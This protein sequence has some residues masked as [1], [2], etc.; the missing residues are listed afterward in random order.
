MPCVE[1]IWGQSSP[2]RLAQCSVLD[3]NPRR[4]LAGD[5]G[6]GM[7]SRGLTEVG[8]RTLVTLFLPESDAAHAASAIMLAFRY[9]F[10]FL[11]LKIGGDVTA[12]EQPPSQPKMRAHASLFSSCA[13]FTSTFVTTPSISRNDKRPSNILRHCLLQI[14]PDNYSSETRS[15][16]LVVDR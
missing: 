12:F 16:L 4:C 13:P 1:D 11:P 10:D 8:E 14:F 15:L 3:G 6:S 5:G 2:P 9:G 7:A